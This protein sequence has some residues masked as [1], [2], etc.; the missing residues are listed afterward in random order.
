VWLLIK[1]WI[2]KAKAK[3]SW[4]T[5]TDK[6]ISRRKKALLRGWWIIGWITV[7]KHWNWIKEKLWYWW[8]SFEDSIAQV[9][10]ELGNISESDVINHWRW[11]ITYD[12]TKKEIQSY[13]GI[14]TKIDI[15]NA[16]LWM[17]WRKKI[18]W[19]DIKFSD[20]KQMIHASNLINYIKY[21][22]KWRC[23]SNTPFITKWH[24]WDIYIKLKKWSNETR[25]EEIISGWLFSSLSTICPDLLNWIFSNKSNKDKFLAYLNKQNM[26]KEWNI[27]QPDA[28]WD[29]VQESINKVCDDIINTPSEFGSLGTERWPI[30]AKA[31]NDQKT[32]YLIESRW[33][34]VQQETKIRLD[35]DSNWNIK[36]WDIDWLSIQ[37]TS[38]KELVRTANLVN[39]I[40]YQY[41]VST[42]LFLSPGE[43]AFCWRGY[44]WLYLWIY[45]DNSTTFSLDDRI[46]KKSTLVSKMPT[47]YAEKT[48]FINYLNWLKTINDKWLWG[49]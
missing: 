12:E 23:L 1:N 31:I 28:N 2:K 7:V 20:Y 37:F 13:S 5:E 9:E 26:W 17:L 40:K 33:S 24:T 41:S 19:L 4:W 47:V 21:K 39:K 6:K 29:K 10:A 35:V 36:S 38:L 34:P 49:K 27:E 48:K 42:P 14:W 46:T 44:L 43:D 15:S 18:E 32:E 30:L 16:R 45:V 8:L 25:D 22:Y 3:K 11:K